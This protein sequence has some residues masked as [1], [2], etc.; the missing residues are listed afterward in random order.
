[1]G[2]LKSYLN[3]RNF[4]HAG[5]VNGYTQKTFVA[6]TDPALVKSIMRRFQER[7]IVP[8]DRSIT[9]PF[10]HLL[11]M[12]GDRPGSGMLAVKPTWKNS[13]AESNTPLSKAFGE[14]LQ[15]MVH[16]ND[17]RTN[18]VHARTQNP[19]PAPR[20]RATVTSMK[21]T[22]TVKIN[23]RKWASG[24]ACIWKN[25]EDDTCFGY[26]QEFIRWEEGERNVWCATVKQ[27]DIEHE[28][29]RVLYPTTLSGYDTKFIF[30]TQLQF[31][32]I[33]D[34]DAPQ[35]VAIRMYSTTSS[36]ECD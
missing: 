35:H 15:Q 8:T 3:N 19:S 22:G 6:R 20:Y 29:N 33:V 13:R 16:V 36:E 2:H 31:K 14:F 1:V 21:V 5:M 30:W 28:A 4:A 26:V 17:A 27:H 11:L 10:N 25:D 9:T 18:G 7:D 24:Q 23:G 34:T 12:R 32:C